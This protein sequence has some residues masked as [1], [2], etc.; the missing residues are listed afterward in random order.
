MIKEASQIVGRSQGLFH[1][2]FMF[3][4]FNK[5]TA[6]CCCQLTN[7]KAPVILLTQPPKQ[8]G[9]QVPP[10][11]GLSPVLKKTLVLKCIIRKKKF[12]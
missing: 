12:A 9:M 2:G 1:Q 5:K 3:L 10:M 6:F 11:A 8:L 4:F 7:V